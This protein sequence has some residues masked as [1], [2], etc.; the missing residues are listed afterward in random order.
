MM[1]LMFIP[2][3]LKEQSAGRLFN[4]QRT[5]YYMVLAEFVGTTPFMH[6]THLQTVD[7]IYIVLLLAQPNVERQST[8]QLDLSS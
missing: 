6:S 3:I 4:C 8:F 2:L 7:Y 1:V 5:T